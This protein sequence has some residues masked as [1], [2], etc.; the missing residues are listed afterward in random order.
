MTPALASTTKTVAKGP[1]AKM[2]I[3]STMH[4]LKLEWIM[5]RD[6]AEKRR[7]SQEIRRQIEN[8]RASGRS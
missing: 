8:S 5:A 3:E 4:H 1:E 2:S 6:E 7:V